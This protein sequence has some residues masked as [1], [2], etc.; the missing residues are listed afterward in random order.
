MMIILVMKN[1]QYKRMFSIFYFDIYITK[2]SH[3]NV[4]YDSC[5]SFFM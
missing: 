3:E 4:G 5:K 2:T 1:G